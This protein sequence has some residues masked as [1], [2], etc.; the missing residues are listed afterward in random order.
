MFS[1]GEVMV[2]WYTV[3]TAQQ[4]FEYKLAKYILYR[5]NRNITEKKRET[6]PNFKTD[7]TEFHHRN[8][9][10]FLGSLLEVA[11]EIW[12]SAEQKQWK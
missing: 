11:F 1:S 12:N 8:Y 7:C 4:L 3:Y 9:N 5:Y 6:L 2:T 10:F